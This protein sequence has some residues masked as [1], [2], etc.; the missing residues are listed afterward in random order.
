[1]IRFL[2]NDELNRPEKDKYAEITKIPVWIILDNVR[3]G[4]NVG[5]VFRTADAFTVEGIM[6]CGITAQPP[7]RD[8]LKSALGATETVT[9]KYYD[10]TQEALNEMKDSGFELYAIEQAEGSV[11]LNR[12]KID[13]NK[14]FGLILGHEVKG[15][16]PNLISMLDGVIEVPQ[17]GTKHSLNISVCCGIVV[18]EFYKRFKA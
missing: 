5:S 7:E 6:I 9:W 4:L 17:S 2:K 15:V 8:I 13:I 18:W 3:S 11:D 10:S 12:L 1:M 14:K 16:D